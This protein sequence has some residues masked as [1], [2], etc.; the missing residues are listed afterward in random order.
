MVNNMQIIRAEQADIDEIMVLIKDCIRDMQARGSDQ[1]DETYPTRAIFNGDIRSGTLF[2]AKKD[3]A[4][5]AVMVLNEEQP[6]EYLK[7]PWTTAGKILTVHRLAVLPRC[8][9]QGIGQLLMEFAAD[10]GIHN[11]YTAIHLDTYSANNRA[12]GLFERCGY[13]RLP[14]EFSFQG[15]SRPFYAFEK[16]LEQSK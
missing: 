5:Q 3:T 13:R 15:R 4:I 16:K 8:Q 10:Y 11:G 6:S 14:V 12:Q 7:L 1:W 2:L 9:Q